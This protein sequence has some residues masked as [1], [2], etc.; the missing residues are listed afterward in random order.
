VQSERL[1]GTVVTTPLFGLADYT[2]DRSPEAFSLDKQQPLMH[3]QRAATVTGKLVVD[4]REV[5]LSGTGFRDRTW[6][7]RDESSSV[8]EY[9]GYMFVFESY[10]LTAMKLVGGSGHVATLGFQLSKDGAKTVSGMTLTRDAAGL[11]AGSAVELDGADP[12][13]FRSTGLQA[14]FWCPMGWERTGPTL[15]AYDEFC[16]LKSSTGLI[17][18][19][20]IEQGILKQLF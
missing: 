2:G 7:Y 16:E 20:L 19:G 11:F 14:G 1:S 4:G 9:F 13:E 12:L 15:S 5:E 17:G 3:Y 18:H 10:A 8:A 6:G